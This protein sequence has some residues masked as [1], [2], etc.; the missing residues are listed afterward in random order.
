MKAKAA[1]LTARTTCSDLRRFT[2]ATTRQRGTLCAASRKNYHH[3]ALAEP[4]PHPATHTTSPWPGGDS[5]ADMLLAIKPPASRR[6]HSGDLSRC[7]GQQ[8]LLTWSGSTCAASGRILERVGRLP[9]KVGRHRACCGG[10]RWGA[11]PL[12]SLTMGVMS[13]AA[14]VRAQAGQPR[15]HV[16]CVSFKVR[17]PALWSKRGQRNVATDREGRARWRLPLSPPSIT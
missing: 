7:P 14:N 6:A 5:N 11:L 17:P 4:C 12:R 16:N 8:G 13:A 15:L 9:T 2:T 1:R 3:G 10:G